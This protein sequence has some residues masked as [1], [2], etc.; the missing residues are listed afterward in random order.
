MGI[1]SDK[2]MA[3]INPTTGRAL[4]GE[5][6]E[7]AKK[8]KKWPRCKNRV[9]KAA[10]F[11]NKCGS[12]APGG[13][14][15][16]PSC[17]KWIGN[18]SKF[19]PHCDTPLYPETRVDMAGGVWRKQSGVF[20]Q[21]FEIGDIKRLLKKDLQIQA[22][23]LALMLDGGKF[24]GIMEA[25]QYNPDSL[26]RKINH[27]GTPPPRSAVLIDAAE[28][29]LPF[30]VENLRSAESFPLEFYG[31]VVVRFGGD[32]K[33][34]L[35]FIENKFKDA[36]AISYRDLVESLESEVRH[37]VD[38]MCVK[39]TV[40]DL[41]RDPERRLRLQ[42]E[43]EESVGAALKSSGMEVM[44]VSSAEFSGEKYEELAEKLGEIETERR[45]QEYEGQIKAL[46]NK[47][48][49]N[50]FKSEADLADYQASLAHEY[51]INQASRANELQELRTE[52]RRREEKGE[53]THRNDLQDLQNQQAV[54][55]AVAG[56]DV[57]VVTAESDKKV[58]EIEFSQEAAETEQALKW[59]REKNAIKQEDAQ[60]KAD[61]YK[62]RSPI[63]MLT[64]TDDPAMR[65][66]LLAVIKQQGEAG[67]S[68]EQLLAKAA[69]NSSAAADALAKI[70]DDGA[71]Y[72]EVL[73]EM[74]SLYKDAGD[75]QDKNLKVTLE[76]AVE[77]AKRADQTIVK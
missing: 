34:A 39:S 14:W 74:K 4:S 20:A 73:E 12:P 2:C 10:R 6:L 57:K 5:A 40:D 28:I 62:G 67:L 24:K 27:F 17:N 32:K 31:E 71:R 25:G 42:S 13:W 69:E 64:I 72:R 59:R 49:L 50:D 54:K 56:G 30:Q 11:C 45:T 76:P 63:E 77:A 66:D 26:L 1:L 37:A 9:R 41:V 48:R 15:R 68:P 33:A 29:V 60:A 58:R 23:T 51:G 70:M 19:C 47:E 22:G 35:A 8:D 36:N 43:I 3:L 44:R 65:H 55:D 53:L 7:E 21:R 75:R 16:C 38:A 18:D 52:W 46:L 61:L